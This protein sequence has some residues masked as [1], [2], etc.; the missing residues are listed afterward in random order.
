MAQDVITISASASLTDCMEAMTAH[1]IRHLPVFEASTLLGV[2]SIGEVVRQVIGGAAAA[3]RATGVLHSELIFNQ[4]NR[5][6][7]YE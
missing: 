6:S 5:R 3:N 7:A 4:M 2:L 1:K